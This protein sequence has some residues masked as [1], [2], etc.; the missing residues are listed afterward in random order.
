MNRDTS[1]LSR[2]GLITKICNKKT[3]LA[4]IK[5]DGTIFCAA[6]LRTALFHLDML[7]I[8]ANISTAAAARRDFERTPV[9]HLDEF[10]APIK[11]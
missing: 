6:E 1:G 5:E 4:S 9:M 7:G 11:R 10:I 3:L 8:V 2:F